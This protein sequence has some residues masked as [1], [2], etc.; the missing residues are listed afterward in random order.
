MSKTYF[1]GDLHYGHKGIS[2]KFR[3]QF[4]SDE[5][6]HG[7]L[8]ENV[9]SCSNKR[10]QLF[11]LGDVA[12]KVEY[13]KFIKDYIDNFQQV[14]IVLGNHDHKSLAKFAVDNGAF[15]YGLTKKFGM[16]LSH[17]PIHP[18]E[19]YSTKANIHG[20][21][22]NSVITKIEDGKSVPAP[23][24]INVCCEQVNYKPITLEAI[25]ERVEV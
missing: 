23:Y 19:R 17:C 25:R 22:H 6:H 14:H 10:N 9:L 7:M 4:S 3:T 5:E 21:L 8:H 18:A 12:F 1:I 20:H 11:L 16:W 24:Y 2:D 15:V 13:F